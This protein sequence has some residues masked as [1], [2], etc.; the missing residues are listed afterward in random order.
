MEI[1]EKP[2]LRER[3][4][5]WFRKERSPKT[6]WKL[7][8]GSLALCP[9]FLLLLCLLIGTQDISFLRLG[10]YFREPVIL[11]LNL[12]PV[13]LVMW[14]LYLLTN[15]VWLSWLISSV[16][17]L[18]LSFVNY[19][20]VALR[21]E[22]LVFD[23]LVLA[24][25]GMGMVG[26]Y[27]LQ[28]PPIFFLSILLVAAGTFLLCHFAKGKIPLK[29][30]WVRILG[31]GL[32]VGMGVFSWNQWYTDYYLYTNTRLG[33]Q[34]VFSPWRDEEITAGGGLFWS[35]LRS[36][37]EVFAPPPEGY[38][39]E[40][41]LELLGQFPEEAIPENQRVN[42]IATM[43]ESYSD[44]S[45]L[46][47]MTFIR[48]PYRDLH[49]LQKECYTGLLV[50]DSVGGGTVNAE[51]A[52]LTGFT[53]R[54]PGY[55]RSTASF[56]RYF[57]ENGYR[58][59]GSHPG[60]SWFYSRQK[61]NRFLGFETY[62]FGEDGL[63]GLV[64]P[65]HSYLGYADD[66]LFFAWCREAYENRDQ[67]QPYFSFNVTFQGH[68]P[69]A[70]DRL[71]GEEYVSHEG[72]S[73]GAYYTV[74]NYLSS[75]ADTGRQMAAFVDA[76]RE[77]EEP[78]VLI[79]FGDHKPTLGEENCYYEELGAIS[80][81]YSGRERLHLYTTPY[82]IWANDAAKEV[83]GRDFAGEGDTISPC[84]LMSEVFDCCGWTGSSWLQFQRSVRQTLPV[85]HKGSYALSANTLTRVHSKASGAALEQ[86][87]YVEYYL[88]SLVP[89]EDNNVRNPK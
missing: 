26:N 15:R 52:F 23:D 20:K 70:D 19:F 37:D 71:T 49:A 64:T 72:L 16:F 76:F 14:A 54:Q 81:G 43:L 5:L 6:T 12:L 65:E 47:N 18:L 13:A 31:L 35:L 4:R 67:S 87:R 66:S 17:F 86:Y 42:V 32:C 29:W 84:Y 57:A 8:L 25:E 34:D 83:L 89:S 56:V 41:V 55:Q 33:I 40:A 1:P 22:P 9:V 85:M 48:D 44:F 39:E 77:D 82:L 3:L 11:L 45:I 60:N 28:F 73:D 30:C 24:D 50:A 63:S 79:F 10:A 46:P 36:A 69:Y 7:T 2:G 88:R 21:G 51:R 75:V 74:N 38:Q 78:V 27:D 80:T 62:S 68:S 58:T 61:V 53:Y 59:E